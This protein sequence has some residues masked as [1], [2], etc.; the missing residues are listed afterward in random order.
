MLLVFHKTYYTREATESILWDRRIGGEV[1]IAFDSKIP[2]CEHMRH[3][4]VVL[5][6]PLDGSFTVL[7]R[8][9]D[10]KIL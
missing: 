10:A 5:Q 6:I 2:C 7:L 1:A 9:N 3:W 4:R 8:G